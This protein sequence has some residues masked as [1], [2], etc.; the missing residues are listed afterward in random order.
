MQELPGNASHLVKLSPPDISYYYY[1]IM[2][3]KY[4]VINFGVYVLVFHLQ[5]MVQLV[6]LYKTKVLINLL[7]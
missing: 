1:I 5:E 3:R 4:I 7:Y 2:L 6:F